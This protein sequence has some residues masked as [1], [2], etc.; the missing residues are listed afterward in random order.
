MLTVL[1]RN[2]Y[3]VG[4]YVPTW[5]LENETEVEVCL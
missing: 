4:K 3:Y 1:A 2:R 5:G